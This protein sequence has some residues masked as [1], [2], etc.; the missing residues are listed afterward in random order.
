MA[1]TERSPIAVEGLP[2][3]LPM[4]AA[5]GL[6][7]WAGWVYVWSFLLVLT[8]FTAYFFR[9]PKREIPP[10]NA[11][12]V[13]PADGR[14]LQVEPCREERFIQSEATKV[15]IFMSLFDVHIN[16]S[17]VAGIVEQR[18]YN[19]GKF[20]LANRDKASMENEQN[21][22]VIRGENGLRVL[23]VQI[24]GLVARRIACYP[25]RGDYLR[26]GEILGMIRFGSRLDVYL[27]EG[28]QATVKIGEKVRAGETVLGRIP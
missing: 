3:V 18:S 16:R 7:I 4:A 19:A 12:V 25:E 14:V 22:M 9:N 2:F 24:A 17:P 15:S 11:V 8:V 1:T 13:S 26:K 28:V 6:A 5:T 10:S 20:H 23:V 27:P 21:A